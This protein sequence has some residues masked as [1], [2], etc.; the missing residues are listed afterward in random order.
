MTYGHDA[1]A[2][3]SLCGIAVDAVLEDA[4]RCSVRLPRS[5]LEQLGLR[6]GD[7]VGIEGARLTHAR[8]LPAPREVPHEGASTRD[9][10][11]V[12][13]DP[14]QCSNAG[15]AIGDQFRILPASLEPAETITLS[16]GDEPGADLS[17]E[18]LLDLPLTEGDLIA[19]PTTALGGR[20][21][22]HMRA[23][24]REETAR[25][26]FRVTGVTPGPAARITAST[27]IRLTN[28]GQ[29]AG[30][31]PGVGGL[32]HQIARVREMIS[33]P[34]SRPDLFEHLG[35]EPPRG[36]LFTG[37]PGSG[38]TLLARTIA[39]EADAAFF[40]IDGPEIVSKHY[41]DS[42]KQLR[43]IFSRARR[44]APAIVFIDEI[45]AIAPRRDAISGDRQLERRIVSTLLTLLDGVSDRGRVILIAATN[46]P[47]ALDPAL[48]RPGRFDREIA[49]AAPDSNAR[50]EILGVH[51]QSVPLAPD[52]DVSELAADTPGFVGADLAALVREAG[53]ACLARTGAEHPAGEIATSSLTVKMSDFAAARGL[54]APSILRSAAIEIPETRWSD[55]GGLEEVKRALTETVIWPIR[56]ASAF[57]KLGLA[58]NSGV[59]LAGPPGCGKTLVARALAAEAQANFVS[60][61]GAQLLS[62][63]LGEAERAVSETF[64]RARHA[65]PCVLFFDELDA[66]APARGMA[67][68]ALERVI[69]ELLVEIDGLVSGGS[70]NRGV[71][72]LG[73]TNRPEA[74]DPALLRP[75]RFD[76]CLTLSAP[77]AA[78]RHEILLVHTRGLPLGSVDIAGLA[79]CTEGWSGAA[80]AAL[81]QGAGRSALRRHLAGG[82]LDQNDVDPTSALSQLRIEPADFATSLV[83]RRASEATAQ[84]VNSDQG[85]S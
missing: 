54:V 3:P 27:G 75:G 78:A 29:I 74:I 73:A 58:A 59:L 20:V 47:H 55:I 44:E 66:L 53:L 42:E 48:R 36:V 22:A 65:A 8:L 21:S 17:V 67:D 33:L 52:V 57:R 10:P 25:S 63:Y 62:Q 14:M 79:A 6:A 15:I 13:L 77:D 82:G 80:L 1:P 69:A 85:S 34:L 37:P 26:H 64:A 72:L 56:H 71:F 5:M 11:P 19:L 30:A 35:I 39:A 70:G 32:G 84:G 7:I 81:V 28:A 60:V 31:L 23:K 18:D 46:L 43:E 38:K 68:A 49:F 16:M 2:A 51:L 41:G 83:E 76:L 50:R 4:F 12:P 45:D 61:R 24:R 9:A 40:R